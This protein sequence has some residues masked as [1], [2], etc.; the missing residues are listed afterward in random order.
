MAAKA[1]LKEPSRHGRSHNGNKKEGPL[2]RAFLYCLDR[3][4]RS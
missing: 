1:F 2:A 3:M 4:A